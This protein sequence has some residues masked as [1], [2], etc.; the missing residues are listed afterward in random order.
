M[1]LTAHRRAAMIRRQAGVRRVRHEKRPVSRV[2]KRMLEAGILAYRRWEDAQLSL[3]QSSAANSLD[4]ED[5]IKSIFRAMDKPSF[6]I[7]NKKV[8]EIVSKTRDFLRF[9][10]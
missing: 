7:R 4:V 1:D 9:G 5:L 8:F 10:V 3:S 2:S 6:E